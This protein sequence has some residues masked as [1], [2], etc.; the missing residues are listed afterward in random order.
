MSTVRGVKEQK[1]E[2]KRQQKH[3]F[4][5]EMH[6]FNIHWHNDIMQQLTWQR[7]SVFNTYEINTT[8]QSMRMPEIWRWRSRPS[9]NTSFWTRMR[10]RHSLHSNTNVCT[11]CSVRTNTR[12]HQF[13]CAANQYAPSSIQMCTACTVT[14]TVCPCNINVPINQCAISILHISYIK[15]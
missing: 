1:R 4:D 8:S 3:L 2:K 13:K 10:K 6:F 5:R 11:A 9:K 7:M 14:T 15:S 12:N